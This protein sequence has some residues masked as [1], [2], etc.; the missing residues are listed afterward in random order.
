MHE[1]EK[2]LSAATTDVSI[3]DKSGL[4]SFLSFLST[5]SFFCSTSVIIVC[6]LVHVSFFLFFGF[7]IQHIKTYVLILKNIIFFNQKIHIIIIYASLTGKI[8]SIFLY[9]SQWIDWWREKKRESS[10]MTTCHKITLACTRFTLAED[11]QREKG[12]EKKWTRKGKE[13]KMM[14]YA[15]Y[16]SLDI[17]D[18]SVFPQVYI[19][20][21]WLIHFFLYNHIELL[22]HVIP[23]SSRAVCSNHVSNW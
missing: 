4:L 1:R 22:K 8:D 21:D 7:R 11:R 20:S 19:Y 23:I 5:L 3:R 15:R 16:S 6:T 10:D 14:K 17:L 2:D 9:S 12:I 13:R 18:Q